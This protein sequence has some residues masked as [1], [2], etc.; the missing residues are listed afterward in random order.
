MASSFYE[1]APVEVTDQPWFLNCVL[2]F[3]TGLALRD[4]LYTVL[5]I[6]HAMGRQRTSD[7]GPRIID[8][9]ILLYGHTVIEEPGLHVPHPAMH[10]RRFVLEPLVEIAADVVHPLLKKTA[11]EMLRELPGGQ[12]V[13]RIAQAG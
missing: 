7:K 8:I 13:H 6:E 3:E 10:R 5:A 1:T 12:S 4:L 11:R 9:D 2:A